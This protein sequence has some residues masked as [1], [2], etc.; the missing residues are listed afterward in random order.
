MGKMVSVEEATPKKEVVEEVEVTEETAEEVTEEVVEEKVETKVEAIG[1]VVKR[2][3]F[4]K[5]KPSVNLKVEYPGIKMQGDVKNVVVKLKGV[6]YG[7]KLGFERRT[8]ANP[9]TI[10]NEQMTALQNTVDTKLAELATAAG[11]NTTQI[12][13]INGHMTNHFND[14]IT[15]K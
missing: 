1:P 4:Y 14:Y 10:T 13:Y 11:L 12:G 6:V 8:C 2:G 3:Q 7:Q 9:I 15:I 5:R